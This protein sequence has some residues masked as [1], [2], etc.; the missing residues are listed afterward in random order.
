[1]YSKL[2]Y[3]YTYTLSYTSHKEHMKYTVRDMWFVGVSVFAIDT[4]LIRS[5]TLTNIF[6]HMGTPLCMYDQ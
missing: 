1:M 6:I 2:D 4:F 5:R 3:T